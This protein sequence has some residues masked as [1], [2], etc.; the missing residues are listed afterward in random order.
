[1]RVGSVIDEARYV[2]IAWPALSSSVTYA[3]GHV[4][5]ARVVAGAG[6]ARLRDGRD[7]RALDD[8][9]GRD[10]RGVGGA[11]LVGAGEV[12]VGVEAVDP[13]LDAGR[14]LGVGHDGAGGEVGVVDRVDGVL[15][16][17]G[18]VGQH[19]LGLADVVGVVGRAALRDRHPALDRDEAREQLADEQ[20]DEPEVDQDHA[21]A[22]LV[23]GEHARR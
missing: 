19:E 7:F 21:A 1:M 5:L 4:D 16:G 9:R 10:L 18:R 14:Q 23:D 2:P 12:G 8:H 22:F 15:V 3:D 17:R 11:R 13:H 20:Q 6:V